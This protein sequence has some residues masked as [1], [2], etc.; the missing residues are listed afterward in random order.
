MTQIIPA[1]L[2][3]DEE[4][5]RAKLREIE[6]SG[7]FTNGWLHVDLMDGEFV[8]NESVGPEILEKYSTDLRVEAHLMVKEPLG[9]LDEL[10]KGGAKRIIFHLEVGDTK[11]IISRVKSQ[12][13]EVGLAINPETKASEL[14]SY[15]KYLDAVLIMSV[16]PGAQGQ[17]FLKESLEKVKEVSRLR[18]QNNL[19]F[20]IGMD[21]GEDEDV[22]KTSVEAGVDYLVI[23]S[24]LIEGNIDENF[25]KIEESLENS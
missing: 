22:A 8:K 7:D 17:R 14:E 10:K 25:E 5:Y 24:H 6:E 12:G 16:H 1:I 4:D 9:Y 21:G 18:S 11:E 13:F 2:S 19:N 23:G 20:L 15:L 3:L